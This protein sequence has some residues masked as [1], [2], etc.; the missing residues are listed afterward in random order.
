MIDCSGAFV[1]VAALRAAAAAA[2]R[3]AAGTATCH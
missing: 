2:G 1:D 3:S